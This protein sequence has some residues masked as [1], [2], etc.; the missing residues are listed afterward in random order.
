MKFGE[1]T[2]QVSRVLSITVDIELFEALEEFNIENSGY[3]NPGW[4]DLGYIEVDD[5]PDVTDDIDKILSYAYEHRVDII[6]YERE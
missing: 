5:H 3:S 6:S 4:L 1:I 2:E